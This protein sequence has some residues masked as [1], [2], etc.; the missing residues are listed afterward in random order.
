MARKPQWPQGFEE[1]GLSARNERPHEA[2]IGVCVGAER[3]PR[4]LH[5]T[6]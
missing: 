1:E 2:A 6:L 4:L 5:R 3:L